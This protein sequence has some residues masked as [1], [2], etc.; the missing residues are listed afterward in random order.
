[1]KIPYS[2]EPLTAFVDS[3]SGHYGIPSCDLIVYKDGEEVYRHLAGFSDAEGKVPASPNDL[4]RLYSA[5]KV[6]TCTAALRLIDEGKLD[7]EDPVSKY[8]PAYAHL[9]VKQ[10]DGSIAP[11]KNVM[12]VRHLFTMS[13]GLNYD[14]NRG[15]S[16]RILKE[17]G[18]KAGTVEIC[19][20]YAEA[21]L[22]FEPGTHFQYSLCHDVLGAVIEAASGMRF[23]EYLKKKIFEPLGMTETFF[24]TDRK[25][26]V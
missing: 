15:G 26:V 12:T 2:F 8:L 1:M 22:D 25:S 24:L 3:L 7:L 6:C 13:A 14:M 18:E 10:P 20:A 19:N 4:Y 5:T 11:A 16:P 9:T 21:P 17:K 23:G